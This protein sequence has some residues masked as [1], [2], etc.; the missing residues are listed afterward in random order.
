M[1]D[2]ERELE[3]ICQAALERP[4]A[5]RAGFLAEACGGDEGLRREAESLLARE[6]AAA[7]FL[8]APALAVAARTMSTDTPALTAGRQIGPFTIVAR[9]GS[10]GM[11]E[12]YR[13]RDA[14]LRRE[15]AIKV[16]PTIFTSD[17][18]RLGRFERE[19]RVLA[20]LNH[21]NIATI[22]GIEHVDGIHALILEVVEG[23]TLAERLQAVASS[24]HATNAGLP[25]SDAL[26][27]ARQIAEA[28]EAAHEKGIVHR[29]LKPANIKIRPD[30]VVKVL[31]FGL[32]KAIATDGSAA[33]GSQVPTRTL[34]GTRAGFILG[35]AAYMSPEQARGKPV[36]TRTDI[37]A[38]GCV[39]YEMLTGRLAFSGETVS[40]A[41][42]AILSR[43]PDWLAL[44]AETPESVRRLLR[45]SVEKD[46]R[47]RVHHIADARIELEETLAQP[48]AS[49]H[50]VS[51]D[52]SAPLVTNGAPARVRVRLAWIAATLSGA[53]IIA[54]LALWRVG[55]IDRP[56][57]DARVYRSSIVLPEGTQIPGDR[58]SVNLGP[59][60][61]FALSPDGRLLAF[62]ARREGAGLPML[63]V[64]PL[65]TDVAQSLA[66]TEGATY[67]FWSPDS[68]SVAFLAQ[69]KLKKIDVAG[70]APLTLCDAS[71]GA[72][73]AWNRDDVILFTPKGGSPIHRVSASGGTPS[74]VTTFDAESGDTQHWFPF[75]LPD[76][77]HFLYSTLGSKVGAPDPRGV[78][79]G[80]LDPDESSTLLLQGGSNAK[81]AVG[82][83]IFL[84]GS[85][86]MARPFDA[87]RRELRGEAEPLAD[88][89]Q[90]TSGSVTGEAGAFTV[91]ET[92]VL[93]YQ[94]G[95]G[96]VRSQLV[97][98]DRAGKQIGQLGDQAD[99]SDVELSPDG[100]RVAVSVLDPAE[101]TR[102]L[103]LYD[104]KRELRTRFT[105]DSAN[106][107][108]PIWSPDSARLVFARREGNVDL[109]EKPSSG[110]NE[111]V[112]LEGGLGKFPSDWS[113]N[114]RFILY[115]AGGAAIARS[116]LLV[117]PLFGDKKPFAFLE[118]SFG[119]TRGRF[120]PD[121]R[122]IAY[123]S[124]ESGQ[125]EIYVDRF[126]KLGEKR[127][128][129]TAGG[130]WPRWRRD[131]REIVYLAPGDTLTAA[132]VNGEGG[133]FEAGAAR[134]LFAVRPRPWVT[135][136]A[137]PYDVS[138]DGQRFLVNTVVE[139]TASSAITLV[140][141]WTAGLKK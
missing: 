20:S 96:V 139:E 102:D 1:R 107:F 91:S 23:E 114:G 41:V 43:E 81:Y 108:E 125:F 2:R 47:R 15:V 32:A 40:D 30:G 92:G 93:A 62:V 89:L 131:G 19:A 118:T 63:W 98:F 79:V 90:T 60:G 116:D 130:V 14:T 71:L 76:G 106:D 120:S 135:L 18:D 115:I 55:F 52:R 39:L 54:A 82:H 94:T 42:A 3:Q 67:P 129:S 83:L 101:G 112:L 44:P 122:W 113:P 109:Y 103:W 46:P 77:R 59:A 97:W 75:F 95:S 29:D 36:D 38:F 105:F 121:G 49:G 134:P 53:A 11:G 13:A 104:V 84:R 8:E 68:R 56:A 35:T 126:P 5:A 138:A 51:T 111:G 141:N 100:Q 123:A 117:L 110:G 72:T 74:P 140:V 4:V 78:Y 24:R 22:H 12:V 124:D 64:R 66:G 127:R 69:G 80:S 9:L 33:D 34:D 10:G 25:L 26:A 85:T 57:V 88:Q 132:T 119:E 16:L 7:S 50:L 70:G 45:R 31:D 137:Y 27:V 73:G 87:N 99:Y 61:R 136:G 58:S 6:S 17:P 21:P 133:R 128:V 65:D 37:W 28:L 48:S 86:L